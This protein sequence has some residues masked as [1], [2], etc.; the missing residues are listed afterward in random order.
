MSDYSFDIEIWAE[1]L[2]KKTIKNLEEKIK[3]TNE[4]KS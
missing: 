4:G 2:R 1:A 3:A